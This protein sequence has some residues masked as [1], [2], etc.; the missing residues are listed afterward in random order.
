[1]TKKINV[2]ILIPLPFSTFTCH[3]LHHALSQNS[4]K[5]VKLNTSFPSDFNLLKFV[6]NLNRRIPRR[7]LEASIMYF[8]L[9]SNIS[10]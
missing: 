6:I 3:F 8:K 2:V 4:H 10:F 5:R 7:L 1:M 9:F